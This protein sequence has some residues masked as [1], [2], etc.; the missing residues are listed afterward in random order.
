MDDSY[1]DISFDVSIRTPVLFEESESKEKFKEFKSESQDLF[2]LYLSSLKSFDE[3]DSF[4]E[5]TQSYEEIF[6]LLQEN[7]PFPTH[8]YE[9]NQFISILS[10]YVN[11]LFLLEDPSLFLLPIQISDIILRFSPKMAETFLFSNA[12]DILLQCANEDILFLPLLRLFSFLSSISEEAVKRIILNERSQILDK[13]EAFIEE[14]D[15]FETDLEI[16]TDFVSFLSH[17]IENIPETDIGHINS[18]VSFF[19]LLFVPVTNENIL[20]LVS[21]SLIK[22]MRRFP[23]T[24]GVMCQYNFIPKFHVFVYM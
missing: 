3:T 5:E 20:L 18:F 6:K 16:T 14:N 13:I 17:L 19:L 1:K 12:F 22:T 9:T 2:I 23:F 24:I 21:E 11:S 15:I 10:N 7:R 8:Y 4:L